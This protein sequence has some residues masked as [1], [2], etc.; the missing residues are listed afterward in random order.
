MNLDKQFQQIFGGTEPPQNSIRNTVCTLYF[1]SYCAQ[2]DNGMA[3]DKAA[4]L[5]GV[6]QDVAERLYQER[7]K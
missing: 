2:R 7:L 5:L 1:S 6:D 4:R 3:A